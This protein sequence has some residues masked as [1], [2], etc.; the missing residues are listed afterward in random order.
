MRRPQYQSYIMNTILSAASQRAFRRLIRPV[1]F[2]AVGLLTLLSCG[3]RVAAPV[4]PDPAGIR[5]LFVG[6]SLT[7]WNEMPEMLRWML[8][9]SEIQVGRIEYVAFPDV[10]LQDHWEEGSARSRKR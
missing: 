1:S 7:Y 6:N 9:T 8:E 4:E 10:G 2:I 5:V 3:G